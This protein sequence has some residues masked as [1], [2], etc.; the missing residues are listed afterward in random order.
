MDGFATGIGVELEVEA[1]PGLGKIAGIVG[2]GRHSDSRVGDWHVRLVPEVEAHWSSASTAGF[3]LAVI[4]MV[5]D[6]PIAADFAVLNW[7][8]LRLHCF[9][10]Q[11][12]VL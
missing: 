1:G 7:V 12:Q 9:V 4:K 2:L 5:V 10:A 11:Q 6:L 3:G 8:K